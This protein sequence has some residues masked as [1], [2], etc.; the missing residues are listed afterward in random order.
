MTEQMKP[1][2]EILSVEDVV[3]L[4]DELETLSGD[5]ADLCL[6]SDKVQGLD[7]EMKSIKGRADGIVKEI[8][9]AG[10]NLVTNEQRRKLAEL[11]QC[12]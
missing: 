2:V 9:G 12:F 3:R 11:K 10:D 8:E 7:S 4:L 1:G 6:A 5:Y